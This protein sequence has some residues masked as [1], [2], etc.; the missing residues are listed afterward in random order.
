METFIARHPIFDSSRKS[1]AYELVYR[2]GPGDDTE[3]K[4]PNLIASRIIADICMLLGVDRL[5]DGKKAF[6]KIP[7]DML[8][9]GYASMLPNNLVVVEL[10][11]TIEPTEDLINVCQQLKRDGYSLAL[12]LLPCH[13]DFNPLIEIADV[14]KI[15]T[16]S[17]A[18]EMQSSV[19]EQLSLLGKS[20]LADQVEDYN[21]FQYAKKLGYNYFQG[22]FTSRPT[23]L[24]LKDIPSMKLNYLKLVQEL[25]KPNID[26]SYLEKII[27]QDVS[28]SIKL[29]RFIN[30]AQFSTAK[31]IQSVRHALSLLG[32]ES[33]KRWASLVALSNMSSDKPEE[34]MILAVTR[35]RFCE[36]VASMVGLSH[37][38][39][40]LFFMGMVSLLDAI[41]DRSLKDILT[42][43]PL[44]QD[45][46]DALLGMQN[47]LYDVY[48]YTLSYEEGNWHRV[49]TYAAKLETDEM[50]LPQLYM[51]AVSWAEQNIRGS[52]LSA[53]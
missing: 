42:E 31:E 45:I 8:L 43:L 3:I 35:A 27:K 19:I 16:F 39:D 51:D 6:V 44:A 50:V 36:A 46:K 4:D 33:I 18:E 26:Y 28:L 2:S 10:F 20:L 9:N 21:V 30:S 52:A 38:A 34:L 1:V 23:T 47:P 13:D 12:N 24:A 37:R 40:E 29:L 25:N 32:E 7:Q 17:F 49:W 15:N 14:I 11:D 53:N 5:T 41:L 22:Y 48:R